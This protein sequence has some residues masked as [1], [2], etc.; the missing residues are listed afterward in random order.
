V[1]AVVGGVRTVD[2]DG[3]AL[4]QDVAVGALEGGH[5]AELVEQQVVG[6]HSLFGD[7]LDNLELELVGLCYGLERRRARVALAKSQDRDE[8]LRKGATYGIGVKLSERHDCGATIS[9][10]GQRGAEGVVLC[11]WRIFESRK[12]RQEAGARWSHKF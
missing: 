12:Q 3:D 2:G 11:L 6:R 7:G 5:F 8:P 1:R 4:S 10:C 9:E